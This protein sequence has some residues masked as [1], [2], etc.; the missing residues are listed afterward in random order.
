MICKLVYKHSWFL[1]LRNKINYLKILKAKF[2]ILNIINSSLIIDDFSV[3]YVASFLAPRR[4]DLKKKN[5]TLSAR[6]MKYH[7]GQMF[8][9]S[10]KMLCWMFDD[11]N[12]FIKR[13]IEKELQ[14]KNNCGEKFRFPTLQTLEN[15][16]DG[17]KQNRF[18]RSEGHT[19]HFVK[20]HSV[21]SVSDIL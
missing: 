5:T 2:I 15:F 12:R 20:H 17:G 21:S 9:K 14:T 13:F 19:W 10:V 4:D 11:S 3:P 16:D 18:R 1:H 8:M 6:T 7:C